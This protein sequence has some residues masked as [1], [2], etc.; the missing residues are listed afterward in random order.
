MSICP[1]HAILRLGLQGCGSTGVNS[2]SLT[3]E[4]HLRHLVILGAALF[5]FLLVELE[6]GLFVARSIQDGMMALTLHGLVQTV[7]SPFPLQVQFLFSLHWL[8]L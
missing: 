8:V 4:P 6:P 3:G 7:E 2:G 5:Q 1:D